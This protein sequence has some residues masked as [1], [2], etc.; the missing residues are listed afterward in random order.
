MAEGKV[1]DCIGLKDLA[2]MAD[3]KYISNSDM[4]EIDQMY[5]EASGTLTKTPVSFLEALSNSSL[6]GVCSKILYTVC[7]AFT[8]GRA[9]ASNPSFVQ[10]IAGPRAA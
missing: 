6:P 5:S 9:I 4:Q 10:P 2:A 7:T 1:R 8:C 3:G